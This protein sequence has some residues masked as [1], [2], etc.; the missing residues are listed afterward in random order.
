MGL[1]GKKL[2]GL[3][4]GDTAS[5][6][7]RASALMN[8]DY[9]GAARISSAM[10]EA[11]LERDKAAAKAAQA[12]SIRAGLKARGLSDPDIDV[13]MANPDNASA[14]VYEALKTREG[15][16]GG[17]TVRSID[18]ATGMPR[19]EI[20]P[21]RDSDGNQWGA[22]DGVKQAPLIREGIKTLPLTQG[23]TVAT[24]GAA[25]GREFFPSSGGASLA[26]QV[27]PTEQSIAFLRQYPALAKQFDEMYGEGSAAR[28]LGQG[29]AGPSGPRPFR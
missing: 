25:T 28:V 9:V 24:I 10:Q 5:K 21:G 4:G 18:P 2:G 16:V 17:M 23:G 26:P 13:I 29:G 14:L 1:F 12:Q 27:T 11:G 3:F 8:D 7:A 22:S 19:Y 6:L 15:A 20:T